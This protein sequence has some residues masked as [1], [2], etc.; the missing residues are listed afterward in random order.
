MI[1]TLIQKLDL[2]RR[3]MSEDSVDD[4]GALRERLKE[5]VDAMIA[6]IEDVERGSH[7]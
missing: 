6:E 7:D 2:I 3:R 4:I 5:L 1:Q